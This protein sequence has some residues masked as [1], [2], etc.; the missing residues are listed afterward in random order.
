MSS[1]ANE[2]TPEQVAERA[3]ALAEMTAH[4]LN[5]AGTPWVT[6]LT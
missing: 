4:A 6:R 1:A 3:V 2:L 5:A